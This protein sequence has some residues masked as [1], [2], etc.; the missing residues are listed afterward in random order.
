V[1]LIVF[2]GTG[3]I[4][5]H[6]VDLARSAG[7]SVCVI[8]RQAET[9][10]LPRTDVDYRRIDLGNPQDRLGLPEI[11]RGADAVLHLASSTVPGTSGRSPASDVQTNLVGLLAI[12]E[13]MLVAGTRRLIYLSSG[14][15]VYGPPES[16]PIRED[17]PLNPISSYGIVKVAAEQ[18]VRLFSR[19]RGL[20]SVILRPSNPYGDRQS[21]IGVQGLVSTVLARTL[22]G[23][24]LE[25]WG[26]GSAVR[27]FL[28]VRDLADLVLR[29]AETKVQG[30]FN[31]G[32]GRGTS[33]NEMIAI[34]NKVT[35]RSL[36]VTYAPARSVDTPVSILD[37]SAARSTFGWMPQ[38]D[39]RDGIRQTW[40]W[41]CSQPSVETAPYGE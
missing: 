33:V 19:D 20:S 27:D 23:E 31:A 3:F 11:L 5:T 39:L 17:H 22:S 12:L 8:S 13:N 32:S 38:T 16:V 41:I 24:P 14:G 30:T 40:D 21:G 36:D 4:G 2:G 34:A 28:H 35:G 1:K 9:R 37:S 10:R 7:H 6:V 18:Y 15:A 29:A 25:V 26:D